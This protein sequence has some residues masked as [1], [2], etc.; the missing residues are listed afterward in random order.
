[1]ASKALIAV[2][3]A[4]GERRVGEERG[5]DRLERQSDAELL[6]H[7]GFAGII[8]VHLDRARAKHHV[9]SEVADL[10]HVVQHDRVAAL[11]HHREVGARLVRPHAEPEE[12]EPEPLADLLAL[13]QVARGF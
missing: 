4:F 6:N 1:M 9:E 13:V 8:E 7:I 12:A 3:L 10:G 5:R 11:G 2:G